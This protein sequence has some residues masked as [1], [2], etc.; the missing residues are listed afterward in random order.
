MFNHLHHVSHLTPEE[1][2]ICVGEIVLGLQY[3][4]ERQ[5]VYRDLKL[6]NI[7]IDD[8]NHILLSDFGLARELKT[9][10]RLHDFSGT[11]TYMAPG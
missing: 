4:H 11:V 6:E 8:Q 5:I 10:E 7:L 1:T 2:I 9:G 3:L